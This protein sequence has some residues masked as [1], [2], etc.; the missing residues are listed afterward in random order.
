[1]LNNLLVVI[2]R[3]YCS[4]TVLHSAYYCSSTHSTDTSTNHTHTVLLIL[5][6]ITQLQQLGQGGVVKLADFGT[7]ANISDAAQYKL[8]GSP[9][10][11]APE[12][13]L[14]RYYSPK[15]DIWS[16]GVSDSP[17]P[18]FVCVCFFSNG[19]CFVLILHNDLCIGWS[20]L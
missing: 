1:V 9:L 8:I 15:A 12:V 13:L 17:L 7:A 3:Y 2:V 6:Y 4:D 19:F 16:V 20:T 14:R 5:H 18:L 11:S 10:F